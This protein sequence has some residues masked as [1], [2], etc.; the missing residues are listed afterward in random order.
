MQARDKN[1]VAHITVQR[2]SS[3]QPL[4]LDAHLA[5]RINL[6]LDEG[7]PSAE[8]DAVARAVV[9]VV[10]ARLGS[11]SPLIH[12]VSPAGSAVREGDAIASVEGQSFSSVQE[13]AGLMR[14]APAAVKLE[15]LR[16]SAAPVLE[17][18]KRR[19]KEAMIARTHTQLKARTA[20]AFGGSLVRVDAAPRGEHRLAVVAAT[21]RKRQARLA[22]RSEE[23]SYQAA[24][25]EFERRQRQQRQ[26]S[27]SSSG[28][29]DGGGG[30]R[31]GDDEV[32]VRYAVRR[33]RVK[34]AV[35]LVSAKAHVEFEELLF[36]WGP[37]CGL[38]V[39][40]ALLTK[41]RS[42]IPVNERSQV[43]GLTPLAQTIVNLR[44]LHRQRASNAHRYDEQAFDLLLGL[45]RVNLAASS[46]PHGYAPLH[47]AIQ[48]SMAPVVDRLLMAKAKS[49][50]V[51]GAN[52]SCLQLAA[53]RGLTQVCRRLLLRKANVNFTDCGGATPLYVASAEGH[54]QVVELLLAAKASTAMGNGEMAFDCGCPAEGP[55]RGG[56]AAALNEVALATKN[57]NMPTSIF[58]EA[59]KFGQAVVNTNRYSH[60]WPLFAAIRGHHER[61]MHLLLNRKLR[62]LVDV[63]H[64][65]AFGVNAMAVATTA[66]HAPQPP[67]ALA[68][69]ESLLRQIEDVDVR[70]VEQERRAAARAAAE[71]TA[72]RHARIVSLLES[73]EGTTVGEVMRQRKRAKLD[74]EM[75]RLARANW[76][77]SE[78]YEQSLAILRRVFDG[79]F[80]RREYAQKKFVA[81]KL[82]NI[83]RGKAVRRAIR[84]IVDANKLRC[85]VIVVDGTR[86]LVAKK[87]PRHVGKVYSY[88]DGAGR[89]RFV[90]ALE[91]ISLRDGSSSVQRINTDVTEE[92]LDLRFL[93]AEAHREATRVQERQAAKRDRL[94]RAAERRREREAAAA[95][96]R[97]QQ[98]MQEQRRSMGLASEEEDDKPSQAE[99]DL[100]AL[101]LKLRTSLKAMELRALRRQETELKAIVEEEKRVKL[102]QLV[103][104]QQKI[105]LGRKDRELREAEERAAAEAAAAAAARE[106]EQT[107]LRLAQELQLEASR[108]DVLQASAHAAVVA[109]E[110]FALHPV[111]DELLKTDQA[112]LDAERLQRRRA[113]RLKR[114]WQQQQ[115]E[116]R[117]MADEDELCRVVWDA[118]AARERRLKAMR[119]AANAQR[120]KSWLEQEL[121]KLRS[122][123]EQQRRREVA[124][125]EAEEKAT[126]RLLRIAR[127]LKADAKW[128]FKRLQVAASNDRERT[129]LA[130]LRH[131]PEDRSLLPY[132]FRARKLSSFDLLNL[133]EVDPG[134]ARHRNDAYASFFKYSSSHQLPEPPNALSDWNAESL[135]SDQGRRRQRDAGAR[136]Y[137]P[138]ERIV[139]Y[140]SARMRNVHG[141]FQPRH[142]F[143]MMLAR[144]LGPFARKAGWVVETAD[145]DRIRAKK[146]LPCNVDY[147]PFGLLQLN[148]SG[149]LSTDVTPLQLDTEHLHTLAAVLAATDSV[150]SLDLR[151]NH[152]R[153]EGLQLLAEMLMD[154]TSVVALDLADNDITIRDADGEG[155]KAAGGGGGGGGHAA[156]SLESKTTSKS[157]GARVSED[158]SSLRV[159]TGPSGRTQPTRAND[160]AAGA[161]RRDALPDAVGLVALA[162][163]LRHNCTLVDLNLARNNIGRLQQTSPRGAVTQGPYN[164]TGIATFLNCL[165]ENCGLVRLDIS[166]NPCA[167]MIGSE[168]GLLLESNHTLG[169]LIAANVQLQASSM[170]MLAKGL[171]VNQ[172][173]TVLDLSGNVLEAEGGQALAEGL[174]GNTALRSLRLAHCRLSVSY[175]HL[176]LPTIYSV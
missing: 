9:V 2:T 5:E 109:A 140:A 26:H 81:R 172:S 27:S 158:T 99:L 42:E 74:A 31:G 113:T 73:R 159:Y 170:P 89:H 19:A 20:L 80:A 132:E 25:L 156:A 28:S 155:G 95:A 38:R 62:P 30:G 135:Y 117:L 36:K 152:V 49:N 18:Y 112:T 162:H 76:S 105:E 121:S 126:R 23:E 37:K 122:E 29:S 17:E 82:Q 39:V 101:R 14:R 66:M 176:T 106:R 148:L 130:A 115:V 4:L 138:G 108:T 169:C 143:W 147:G 103:V 127:K 35:A 16:L 161:V 128:S 86:Y 55:H 97:E 149:G 92:E 104:L 43:T 52:E 174:R 136:E 59:Q 98:L 134:V 67:M 150:M 144:V 47:L 75:R 50:V 145:D 107:R 163:A 83:Y 79:F 48:G 68:E 87:P 124:L 22:R 164:H 142:P 129:R 34:M 46:S 91:T 111:L 78:R 114:E 84:A 118:R 51:T 60:C 171:A 63:N 133:A 33:R 120:Q 154:N 93:H 146:G 165:R 41:P 1:A 96:R 94:Q 175:T 77:P 11:A 12:A 6:S 70:A 102:E 65:D 10:V 173:L 32:L 167:P 153:C 57:T 3:T 72:R 100:K 85:D 69:E 40:K 13:F 123:E 110:N 119:D 88:G 166:E 160:S 45:P 61:V 56:D 151:F 131:K 139:E 137:Q 64:I 15:V 24:Q 7:A 44:S 141:Y 54:H 90:G 58:I 71:R 8:V 157:G 21:E 53:R 116:L 168:L 125:M